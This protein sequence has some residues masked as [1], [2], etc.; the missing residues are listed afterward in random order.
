V[1]MNPKRAATGSEVLTKRSEGI[2]PNSGSPTPHSALRTPH[3][4][5]RG[6]ALLIV[7]GILAMLAVLGVTFAMYMRMNSKAASNA[8]DALQAELYAKDILQKVIASGYTPPMADATHPFNVD[9][10]GTGLDGF[11]ILDRR[12]DAVS[13]E[14][15]P[16]YAIYVGL[17]VVGRLNINRAGG[18]ASRVLPPALVDD[19]VYARTGYETAQVNLAR[20][21]REAALRENALG[22]LPFNLTEQDC[23]K[24]ASAIVAQRFGLDGLPGSGGLSMMSPSPAS[25]IVDNNG[26]GQIDEA[27]EANVSPDE[28]NQFAPQGDDS[29]FGSAD[30]LDLILPTPTHSSSIYNIFVNVLDP[31]Y[32][33]GAG[34]T[35]FDA[36]RKYLTTISKDP[37]VTSEGFTRVGLNSLTLS[38]SGTADPNDLS[39][40][41]SDQET[42]VSTLSR[43]LK[44]G[45]GASITEAEARKKALQILLNIKD[46]IDADNLISF[47]PDPVTPGGFIYGVDRHPV[48]N[49]LYIVNRSC[50]GV[51]NDGDFDADGPNNI[52][53]D[54]DD[55]DFNLNGLPDV[56]WDGP[57]ADANGDG[58]PLY[59]PEGHI[60]GPSLYDSGFDPHKG[61][62]WA[63]AGQDYHYF[64]DADETDIFYIELYNPNDA[65]IDISGWH[66][67]VQDAGGSVRCEVTISAGTIIPAYGFYVLVSTAPEYASLV[68]NYNDRIDL[69]TDQF[70]PS[71]KVVVDSCFVPDF[72]RYVSYT[73]LPPNNTVQMY[74]IPFFS[75]ERGPYNRGGLF[76]SALQVTGFNP[77]SGW[78]SGTDA[79][80]PP[81][82]LALDDSAYPSYYAPGHTI[83]GLDPISGLNA[84]N[85][86]RNPAPVGAPSPQSDYFLKADLWQRYMLFLPGTSEP[87]SPYFGKTARFGAVTDLGKVLTCGFIDL[88][89]GASSPMQGSAPYANT[90]PNFPGATLDLDDI[91]FDV[92]DLNHRYIYDYFTVLDPLH[93]NL[94]DD[95]NGSVDDEGE[96]YVYGRI[97]LN[98]ATAAAV[99]GVPVR[100]LPLGR[101]WDWHYNTTTGAFEW[102]ETATSNFGTAGNYSTLITQINTL[103]GSYPDGNIPDLSDLLN[104]SFFQST[105]NPRV[106]P[107][108]DPNDGDDWTGSTF[109]VADVL[110]ES[111]EERDRILGAFMNLATVN[112]KPIAEE[113]SSAESL[114]FSVY[115]IVQLTDGYDYANDNYYCSPS[116]PSPDPKFAF[117][118]IDPTLARVYAEKKL[119]AVVERSSTGDIK[120]LS[121]SWL[122]SD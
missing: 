58:N 116:D 35:A 28:F 70:L 44:R 4:A 18:A 14:L 37:I 41:T 48:I 10:H 87:T 69:I 17:P 117:V 6:V 95:G 120:L 54:E 63:P 3:S 84:R 73:A 96:V 26:Q 74:G 2:F 82:T 71:A 109:H 31:V 5:K 24:L 40:L 75:F 20:G 76:Q 7:L 111:K 101:Q 92:F 105:L 65:A 89:D 100:A 79:S 102:R 29:P 27:A 56:D 43:A 21:L 30:L 52:S 115:I 110:K 12:T 99:G 49:E 25:D 90:D 106:N 45:Y 16:R 107:N 34:Q 32:G 66:I 72:T 62:P 53:G 60:D 112:E 122:P 80:V 46:A 8:L 88:P 85:P 57:T 36:L 9:T 94:D 67:R 1:R 119:L 47:A 98:N 51:D 77:N 93:N 114:I 39:N 11:W 61:A 42:F 38:G 97:D 64:D 55:D 15:N 91:K 19:Y 13:R 121:Y 50:D 86:W 83:A 108:Y 118:V 22:T 104:L 59:D 33:A 68:F 78:T 103:K 113:F 81:Y 23:I